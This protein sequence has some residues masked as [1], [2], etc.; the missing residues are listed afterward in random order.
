VHLIV[1]A[2]EVHSEAIRIAAQVAEASPQTVAR[3][4]ELT[5]RTPSLDLRQAG[6]LAL[7]L[8]TET[9]ASPDFHEGVRAFREKRPPRW[10]SL[11]STV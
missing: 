9:L 8:R 1:P 2:A 5:R 7:A 6:E 10:P 4:L 11:E 3:G